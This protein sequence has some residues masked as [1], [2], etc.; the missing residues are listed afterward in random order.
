M[1][2]PAPESTA[3][4][5]DPGRADDMRLQESLPSPKPWISLPVLVE[6]M[7][8]RAQDPPLAGQWAVVTGSS[9]GIGL[10]IAEGLARAGAGVALVARRADRLDAARRGI[11]AVAPGAQVHTVQADVSSL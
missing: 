3:L 1:R 10:G 2:W 4:W 11:E 9:E 5:S 6:T 7:T 8:E